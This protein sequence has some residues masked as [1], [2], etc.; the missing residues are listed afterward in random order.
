MIN[1]H[2]VMRNICN[3]L[4]G[5]EAVR[6][7]CVKVFGK[8]CHIQL[9]AYGAEGLP[10][11]AE[12]PFI[13]VFSDGENESAGQIGE[14][15]F[16]AIV[17]AGVCSKVEGGTDIQKITPRTEKANGLAVFGIAEKAEELLAIALGIVQRGNHGA[18]FRTAYISGSGTVDYSLQWSRAR[19]SF[20]ELQTLYDDD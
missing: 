3:A 5:S 16:E 2:T 9:D 10:G 17:V 20:Y 19:L 1:H 13:F 12:A 6:S 15:T 7:W 4:T 8:G 18:V 11:E 14:A